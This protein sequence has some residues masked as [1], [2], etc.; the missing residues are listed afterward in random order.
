MNV[1]R[2]VRKNK[3]ENINKM[4][5]ISNDRKIEEEELVISCDTAPSESLE[6]IAGLGWT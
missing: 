5:D 1:R 3:T 4:V 2:V 6:K